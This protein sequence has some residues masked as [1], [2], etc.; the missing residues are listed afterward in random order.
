MNWKCILRSFPLQDW[1]LFKCTAKCQGG[2]TSKI[3][4]KAAAEYNPTFWE[5]LTPVVFTHCKAQGES[6]SNSDHK[7]EKGYRSYKFI[8][9]T[10][11]PPALEK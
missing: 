9:L 3:R 2:R 6:F 5:C 4:D 1:A 7:V 11:I 10:K 8:G